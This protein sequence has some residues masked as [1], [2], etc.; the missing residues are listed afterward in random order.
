MSVEDRVYIYTNKVVE[1]WMASRP[2]GKV[3]FGYII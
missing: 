3:I 2:G 1:E